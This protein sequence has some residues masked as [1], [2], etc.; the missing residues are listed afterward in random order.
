MRAVCAPRGA[1]ACGLVRPSLHEGVPGDRVRI[2]LCAGTVVAEALAAVLAQHHAA[3]LDRDQQPLR[4]MRVR[5][6]P[7]NVM[8]PWPGREAPALAGGNVLKRLEFLPFATVAKGEQ[9]TRFRAGVQRSVRRADCD[10][11]DVPL[12]QLHALPSPSAVR[13]E[14]R[15]SAPRADDHAIAIRGD[16]VDGDAFEHR[17]SPGRRVITVDPSQYV[18][19]GADEGAHCDDSTLR[20]SAENPGSQR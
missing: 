16:T 1:V 7:A 17:L 8:G 9:A 18:I 2:A 6:N 20:R 12:G 14:E 3:K 4:P 19:A 10:R 13:A 5:S 15:P 11:E